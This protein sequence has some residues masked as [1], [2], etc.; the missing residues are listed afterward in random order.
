MLLLSLM[1][2]SGARVQEICDL[3]V[4]DVRLQKPPTVTLTG[5]GRKT[6]FVPIMASTAS[7]LTIYFSDNGLSSP[8][9]P[10]GLCL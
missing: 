8:A 10:T 6:R 3:R 7:A 4:R 5:K 1:Y 9:K 2:D